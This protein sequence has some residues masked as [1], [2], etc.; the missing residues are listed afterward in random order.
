[1]PIK[2]KTKLKS[3]AFTRWP[4]STFRLLVSLRLGLSF[5]KRPYGLRKTA[6]PPFFD[7]LHSRSTFSWYS[8][9]FEALRRRRLQAIFPGCIIKLLYYHA[10]IKFN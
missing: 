6:P 3:Q 7:P 5:H 2:A 8:Y 9:G 10:A 1:M 4:K